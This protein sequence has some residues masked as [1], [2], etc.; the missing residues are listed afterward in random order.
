MKCNGPRD[1][2]WE[3]LRRGSN[4][5]RCTLCGTVYP[6][7]HACEHVDCRCAR[8]EALPHWITT[9]TTTTTTEKP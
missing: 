7:R 4:R 3:R 8:G 5:E 6:C 9:T 2:T 1:H